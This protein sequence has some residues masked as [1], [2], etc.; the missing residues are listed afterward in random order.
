MNVDMNET[1]RVC[2]DKRERRTRWMCQTHEKCML[3]V[4]DV[5]MVQLGGE[6]CNFIH[7]LGLVRCTIR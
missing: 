1:K 5:C 4:W 3:V 7:R 2:M 6:R